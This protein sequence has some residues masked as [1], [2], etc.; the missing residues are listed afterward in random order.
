MRVS[1]FLLLLLISVI[2]CQKERKKYT[3]L[4]N[5]E[6]PQNEIANTIAAIINKNSSDSLRVVRGNG[7]VMNLELLEQGSADFGIVDNYS[8]FSNKITSLLPLYPQVLHILYKNKIRPT[9]LKQL[10]LSGKVFP[11]IDGSGTKMFVDQLIG[12]LGLERKNMQFVSVL[13]LFDADVIFSFTDLLTQEE[14][15]D[16]KAYKLYSIDEVSRL[17]KGSLADGICTRH[18]QFEPFV[19]ATNLYG[20]FSESPVLTIKIDA[21]LVCRADLDKDVVYSIVST[22]A[23]N[24]QDLKNI[25]PLLFNVSGDFDP[26]KL[27]F[28]VHPGAKGFLDRYSPTFL[29]KYADVFSVI[30]SVFVA[31]ASS[32][33]T[34]SQW[35]KTR[36]KNKIDIYY[37]ELL[38]LRGQVP[39]ANSIEDIKALE[40]TI[41]TT[42]EETIDLVVKEK[43]MAD[44][45][46]SIFLNLSKIIMDEIYRKKVALEKLGAPVA[47]S[48]SDSIPS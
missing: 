32:L 30:I 4:G 14:L 22:I 40:E 23:E 31:L 16:L 44:E 19:I 9:S 3:I 42:Q 41:K 20:S 7:S 5:I 6:D 28:A 26:R 15:R 29:E 39:A 33:Y 45:S 37:K 27:N 1:V 25:N 12:D 24:N 34:F 18:P 21:I 35:Q 38:R 43:L 2:G 36:K 47:H 10:L 17:S 46:F 8:R 48:Y 13:D 11:G